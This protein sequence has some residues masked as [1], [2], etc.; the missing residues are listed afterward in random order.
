MKSQGEEQKIAIHSFEKSHEVGH[1]NWIYCLLLRQPRLEGQDPTKKKEPQKT[2]LQ[3]VSIVQ[4]LN[5]TRQDVMKSSRKQQL[6][7]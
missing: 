1:K 6:K 3:I 4:F 5:Y 7:S 2:E